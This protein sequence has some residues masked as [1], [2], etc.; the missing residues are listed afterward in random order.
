[1]HMTESSISIKIFTCLTTHAMH[2]ELAHHDI[3]TDALLSA[4]HK[5]ISR[6]GFVKVSRSD[7]GLNFI[8]SEKELKEA[9][10]QLNHDKIID[11][12]SSK[13]IEWTLNPP[14]SPWMGGVWESLVKSV[15]RALRVITKD[16][17]FTEDSLT[18]F[19]RNVESVIKQHPL[20]PTSHG[21]DSFDAITLYHLLLSSPLLNLLPGNFNQ[22]D[23][24]YRAKYKNVQSATNMFWH[25]WIFS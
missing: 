20:T 17:A 1:M 12:I 24:K 14:I 8:G 9:L 23:M 2:L 13:N 6:R 18:T 16:Q 7:S 11:I 21:I 22:S 15:K 10:K 4:L 25:K 5:F 19:L 3:S